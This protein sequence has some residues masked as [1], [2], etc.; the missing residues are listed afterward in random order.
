MATDDQKPPLQ[1]GNA[2]VATQAQPL[3]ALLKQ[4]EKTIMDSLP[5]HLRPERMMRVCV[6]AI[7]RT[8]DLLRCTPLTVINSIVHL[9]QLG[10]EPRQNEAYLVPFKRSKKDAKGNWTNYWE[11]VPMIDYRGKAK[12]AR[13][14]GLVDDIVADVVYSRDKFR[15]ELTQEGLIFEHKPLK[16]RELEGQLVEVKDRGVMVGAYAVAFF[17]D[18]KPHA[19]FM[20]RSEISEIRN[21][22]KAK[23]GGPWEET[24][25]G[26]PKNE[27]NWNEQA[28]KTAVHRLCKMIP[29]SVEL[30]M[31]NELDDRVDA[32]LRLDNVLG[33]VISAEII[34]GDDD[35]TGL[36]AESGGL[37][38]VSK[39]DVKLSEQATSAGSD[40]G[41]TEPD[42]TEPDGPEKI[43]VESFTQEELRCVEA[44]L[45]TAKIALNRAQ[46]DDKLARWAEGKSLFL[47]WIRDKNTE[48]NLGLNVSAIKEK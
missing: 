44:V 32:G 10:L 14:S 31:A 6:T 12:L 27:N 1:K 42:K 26:Q 5:Q 25:K 4:Y 35:E 17:K 43:S 16:L 24:D 34:N 13:Q 40:T 2:G 8:P 21:M 45:R 38:K 48:L 15:Y 23:D 29:Q 3:I 19:V 20:T 7:N 11:C 22:S 47:G 28:K 18:A 9:S 39:D 36:E 46:L 33:D 41:K 30:S 37:R